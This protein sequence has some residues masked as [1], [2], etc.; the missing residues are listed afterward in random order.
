MSGRFALEQFFLLGD[1]PENVETGVYSV[2]LVILSYAIASLGAFTSLRLARNM[3]VTETPARKNLYHIAG[4]FALGAGIWSMHFVGMLAYKMRM[5]IDY[6]LVLSALSM[7]IAIVVAYAVLRIVN[8]SRIYLGRLALS[9]VFMGAGIC[10]MHYTG[11]ASMDMDAHLYYK[12]APF[13][14]SFLIAIT[15]T[16]AA[17]GIV[18]ILGRRSPDKIIWLQ[19]MAA[20]IMGVAVCGMHYMGMYA[21]VFVPYA[22][23]LYDPDQSFV[24]LAL[25]VGLVTFLIFITGLLLGFR[26]AKEDTNIGFWHIA[27]VPMV[28]T[29]LGVAISVFS[30]SAIKNYHEEMTQ[31]TIEQDTQK[32]TSFFQAQM[33]LEKALLRSVQLFF[34]SSSFVDPQEFH[35]YLSGMMQD[36]ESLSEFYYAQRVDVD[37]KEEF[38]Q[39]M[40]ELVPGY[41]QK[42]LIIRGDGKFNFPVVYAEPRSAEKFIG[43][44]LSVDESIRPFLDGVITQDGIKVLAINENISFISDAKELLFMTRSHNRAEDR[45]KWQQG[46]L[47]MTI[48]IDDVLEYVKKKTNV[49][50]FD[51]RFSTEFMNDNQAEHEEGNSILATEVMFDDV[52]SY[53][54]F[55][56]KNPKIY[57]TNQ[58][59]GT[60][61]L[62]GGLL[63]SIMMAGFSGVLLYQRRKDFLTKREMNVQ[64]ERNAEMLRKIKEVEGEEKKQKKFLDTLLNH[65]PLTIFVKDV[66]NGYTY[67]MMNRQAEIAFGFKESEMLGL[68]DYDFFLEEEADFFRQTDINVM[69]SREI[70]EIEAEPVTTTKGT[71]LG[72][73]IKIP[74]YDDNGEPHLLMGIMEDVTEKQKTLESLREAKRQA[75]AANQAKSDFLANMSH[76]I[77][78]PMNAVLGMSHLLLDTNLTPEQKEWAGA[79]QK[80][81][82]NLL[83]IINDII[84]FSKIEAGKL[85]LEQIEFDVYETIENVTDVFSLRTREKGLEFLLEIDDDI[86]R[87]VKGDP[88]RI[89]QILVN[90][91][92][93]AL[94]FT[95]EGHIA[96]NVSLIKEDDEAVH[97]KFRV[98]DSGIGIPEEKREHIFEKFSQAEE[99]TTRKFGGTG[100]GLAICKQLIRLMHG[101]I[102]V[103]SEMGKG[104]SFIF[105][106]VLAQA[107]Q[108]DEKILDQEVV[109]LRALIVDDYPMTQEILTNILAR[110]KIKSD[111]CLSAEMAM[112]ALT[113]AAADGKPYDLCLVDFNLDGANGL[114]LVK[115][116]RARDELKSMILIMVSGA[117]STISYEELKAMGLD[118]FFRKPFQHK[119]LV[120]AV[121][122][123]R[124]GRLEGKD[125]PL[126]TRHN[127]TTALD[128]QASS[129]AK[130]D[131]KQYEGARVL[132]V[133]DISMNMMLIK[134]VLSKFGCEIDTAVNGLE[135]FEKAKDNRYDLIFMDCQMPEMDGFESTMKIR[136]AE[137]DAG[138][139]PVPIVALTAD[140]MVGDREKCMAAGMNDYVNKPFR[141][142]QIA[143]MFERWV[144]HKEAA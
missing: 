36:H 22:D 129:S 74:I 131:Y 57:E 127:T 9:S 90:L 66:R 124:K 30:F 61:V 82:E 143:E 106:I 21:A 26:E 107:K 71:I 101:D 43:A 8:Q 41:F 81:G 134:K 27:L 34:D 55:E 78:T 79:I 72:H 73:T 103:E 112:E 52:K 116:I 45:E 18:S 37:K 69:E 68:T 139:K 48:H 88:T 58:W 109:G 133:E 29:V 32:F 108:K 117:L 1:I 47:L 63:F 42:P 99:S 25:S 51:I 128:E 12:P 17:M 14:V 54:I 77:R 64:L 39:R 76:E 111:S 40:T 19:I 118:G 104:S 4:A 123:L 16:A 105:D 96:I 46:I 67:A 125:A 84:D 75:E 83:S 142:E 13:L 140:A 20:L 3:I 70:F 31:H 65:M 23:C 115:E 136:K 100:L 62:I 94:K 98:S 91:I 121:K 122:I 7:I 137:N 49:D 97:L 110:A 135:A 56:I 113:K 126:V 86:P 93:N 53:L 15:A 44:D 144:I 130:N 60:A 50:N 95:S 5:R 119:Q 24:G 87:W 102:W 11:M 38:Y 35:F 10:A 114:D 6:D 85:H 92:G 138:R 89:K 59:Q 80:S 141:I 120:D 28:I 33:T 132:A 2:S